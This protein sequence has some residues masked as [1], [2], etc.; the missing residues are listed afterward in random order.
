M[1]IRLS[2][3]LALGLVLNFAGSAQAVIGRPPSCFPDNRCTFCVERE[4]LGQ[5]R[6][7]CVKCER[8][9]SYRC[10]GRGGLDP[11]APFRPFP[12]RR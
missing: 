11:S 9:Y 2:V 5:G 8:R 12:Y 1:F 4:I 6:S 7:R 10:R 3:T